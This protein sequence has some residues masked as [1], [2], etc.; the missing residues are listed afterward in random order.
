[1]RTVAV[2]LTLLGLSVSTPSRAN[3]SS[4]VFLDQGQAW[5]AVSRADFYT[6]DQGSRLIPLAWLTALKNEDGTAFLADGLTRYGYLPGSD[7]ATT[8]PVGF[9]ATGPAGAKVVGMTCSACHTR[10]IKVDGK[11]YRIDGGPALVDFQAFLEDLDKAVARA[12]SDDGTFRTF[13]IAVL[14]TASPSAN[15]VAALRRDVDAWYLRYHTIMDLALPK[16]GWGLGRLDAVG[17]IFNRVT[18]L[19]VGPEPSFLIP[20][21]IRRADAPTRYPFLWNAT[22]Q[23]KTQWPGFADNGSDI[24]GLARNVGEVLGVFGTYQPRRLGPLVNFWNNNSTNIDGLQILEELVKKI[25]PPKWPWPIDDVLAAKGKAIFERPTASGGCY[26]CHGAKA[27]KV[28]F[29]VQQTWA[30]PIQNVGTDTRQYDVL[31]WTAKSG[32]LKGAYIPFATKP[33][34]EVD[35]AFNILATSVIGTIAQHVVSPSTGSS[36]AMLGASVDT[37]M[38][39]AAEPVDASRLPSTLQDLPGAFQIPEAIAT[40]EIRLQLGMNA[41]SPSPPKGAYESRVLHG[42]WAAAPYL[43]NGSVASLADLLKPSSQRQQRFKV[44]PVYDLKRIG[45]ASDQPQ[46]AFDRVTTGCDDLNSGNSR[47]GHEFGTS[48]PDLEKEALLEYLKAL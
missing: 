5:D 26:E 11:S 23:D 14:Q 17:M 16:P 41:G 42:I 20:E 29:P 37:G 39:A 34:K 9:H 43:H 46:S 33:L 6:R 38:A 48:L 27:G 32:I 24:L 45:L 21:N 4:P 10:Q 3:D 19:G 7:S 12:I 47:C 18:G 8:L 1:M 25:E 35:L 13:A 31:A 22:K 40:P 36:S 28:R 2:L 30:T 44:G 15:N